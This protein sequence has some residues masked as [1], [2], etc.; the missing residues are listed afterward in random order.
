M[1]IK[2]II[3]TL[4]AKELYNKLSAITFTQ[5]LKDIANALM[6]KQSIIILLALVITHFI[7]QPIE[8]LLYSKYVIAE[9][10]LQNS[11]VILL[12]L[13]LFVFLFSRGYGFVAIATYLIFILIVIAEKLN[14]G[15]LYAQSL[16]DYTGSLFAFVFI[17]VLI[18]QIFTKL[19]SK[20]AFV[21]NSLLA[22][23]LCFVPLSFIIYYLNFH[24]PITLDDILAVFQTN[25]SEAYEFAISFISF[26]YIA[27]FVAIIII[28]SALFYAHSKQQIA[29]INKWW[30]LFFAVL[31]F[32]FSCT[33]Y[34]RSRMSSVV[35]YYSIYKT[36]LNK[37]KEVQAKR[38]AGKIKFSATKQAKGETYI[39]I[40]GESHNKHHMGLYGYVRETTPKLSKMNK[41]GELLVFG[42]TYSCHTHTMLVLSMALTQANQYNHKDYYDSLSIID[43]FK[44]ANMHTYWLTNQLLYGPADNL[45]SVIG[46]SADHIVAINNNIVRVATDYYDGA[47]I[48]ELKKVL[49]Q[50]TDKNRAIVIHLM[51]SHT[52]YASRYPHNKYSIFDKDM[53]VGNK[54]VKQKALNYYDNT[55]AYNDYVLSSIIKQAQQDKSTYGVIYMSDHGEDAVLNREHY[56]S[57]ITWQMSE[58]P[59]FA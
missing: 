8:P 14:Y 56:V 9:F 7:L 15:F 12:W 31:F 24:H 47:L 2:S 51:G 44:Q 23:L 22:F 30:L 16:L 3:N 46:Q 34:D 33:K 57:P 40:I 36:E 55:I 17:F 39:F 45:A 38:K 10:I 5:K 50:K 54:I 32:G 53:L 26:G 52:K 58:I 19:S 20:I 35:G 1:N 42:N 59:M 18:D 13:F 25:T 4:K 6:S 49:S 48:D 11:I 41:D 27:L 28:I 29:S 37:F 21:I 43:I